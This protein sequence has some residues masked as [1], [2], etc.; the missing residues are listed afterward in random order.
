MKRVFMMSLVVLLGAGLGSAGTDPQAGSEQVKVKGPF[1]ETWVLPDADMSQYSKLYPWKAVFQFRE[2][3]EGG[4]GT[5]A[6][7]LRGGDGPFYV[8]EESRQ[9][10]EK[11]V[12]E[13]FVTELGR[14]KIFEVVDEVGPDTLL[15]RVMMVDIISNVPP[16]FTGTADIY[17]SAVGEATFIFELIDSETGVVQATVSERRRIQPRSQMFQVSS[18]PANAA[19]VWSDVQRWAT[20][21]AR[22]LRKALEK[23]HKKAS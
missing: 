18:R 19:T 3:G 17:I 12:T 16:R 4:S 10:F 15:V 23:A 7:K 8:N 13:T 20:E 9:Q 21:V 14:S 2:V 6:T 1:N 11:M 5:T 22:D